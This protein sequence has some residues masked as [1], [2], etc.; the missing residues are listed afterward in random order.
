MSLFLQSTSIWTTWGLRFLG[1]TLL[2]LIVVRNSHLLSRAMPHVFSRY[3]PE[4]VYQHSPAHG[5]AGHSQRDSCS[6]LTPKQCRVNP[7]TSYI[8]V[9]SVMRTVLS[10]K[11]IAKKMDDTREEGLQRKIGEVRSTLINIVDGC[12]PRGEWGCSYAVW[13]GMESSG[14]ITFL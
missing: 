5:S 3:T 13:T 7:C 8:L 6:L 1:I 9:S 10:K 4:K 12:A 11:D 14:W 2:L